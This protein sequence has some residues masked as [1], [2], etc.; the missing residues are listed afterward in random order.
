[1]D[2]NAS[3]F[4]GSLFQVTDME[5]IRGITGSQGKN[6]P[7]KTMLRERRWKFRENVWFC[8]ALMFSDIRERTNNRRIMNILTKIR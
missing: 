8:L 5:T 3:L 1:M 4:L 7:W 6:L 2:G